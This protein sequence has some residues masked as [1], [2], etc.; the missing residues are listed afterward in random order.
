MFPGG[1]SREPF[2]RPMYPPKDSLSS[3]C[4]LKGTYPKSSHPTSCAS[5]SPVPT[6]ACPASVY[7]DQ[8]QGCLSLNCFYACT[9]NSQLST[10]SLLLAAGSSPIRGEKAGVGSPRLQHLN[11]EQITCG[12]A[13]FFPKRI[14]YGYLSGAAHRRQC[15]TSC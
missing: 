11:P 3:D 1:P 9:N 5:Q 13:I 4:S 8:P 15:H 10:V 2:L 6:A 12:P 14:I 7:K